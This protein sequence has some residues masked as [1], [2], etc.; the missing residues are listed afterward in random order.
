MP[1]KKIE[2]N[3][4]TP[5]KHR[6]PKT[7]LNRSVSQICALQDSICHLFLPTQNQRYTWYAYEK[8]LSKGI[9]HLFLQHPPLT[10][11]NLE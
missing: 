7:Q 2:G 3:F 1:E 8:K 5:V 10:R 6:E 4:A 9:C 11:R